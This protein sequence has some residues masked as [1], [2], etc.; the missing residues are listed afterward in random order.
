MSTIDG[1]TQLPEGW[2]AT[3]EGGTA[4]STKDP[5]LGFL[6]TGITMLVVLWCLARGM[7]YL[8]RYDLKE[9]GAV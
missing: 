6:E 3:E 1:D 8:R 2:N 7:K 5:A 9:V 4:P